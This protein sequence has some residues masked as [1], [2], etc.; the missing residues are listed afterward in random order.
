MAKQVSPTT[1]WVGWIMFGA[2]LLML[3]GVLQ[4][5]SGFAGIFSPDYFVVTSN[6]LL[7]LTHTGWGWLNL[8]IGLLVF[9]TGVSLLSGKAW[10]RVSSVIIISLAA[11]AHLGFLNAYPLWGIVLLTLDVFILY[12]LIKHGNEAI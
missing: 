6:S 8:L 3:N 10:A 1:G 11:I 2:F 7:L 12:A 9:S 5:I 4:M